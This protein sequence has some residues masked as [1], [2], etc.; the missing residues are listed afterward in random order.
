MKSFLT[1]RN[2]A[3]VL[4]A[5]LIAVIALVS[6]GTGRGDGAVTG[7]TSAASK[8]LKSAA[9]AVAR[10]F[11][12]IYGYMYEYENVV[13]ENEVLKQQIADYRQ[14]YREYTEVSEE[15]K[16]LRDLLGFAARHSDYTFEQAT[17][18][19]WGASN[20]AS[21]FTVSRGSSNSDIAVG[22]AVI[23]ETGVLV[24]KITK[25]GAVDSTA[26][27]VID[28][29]F[30]AGALIG[31]R[32]ADGVAVGDFRYM[33]DGLLKLDFLADDTTVL[34]GDT[35]VTSG[36]K[37]GIFPEGLV[38]GTVQ[39][40]MKNAAGIGMYGI[41]EPEAKPGEPSFVFIVTDFERN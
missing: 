25:V 12:T 24:G 13:A 34:A 28:T 4:A 19:M 36:S 35:V 20:W 17:I 26:V 6:T 1:K 21:T 3:I 14:D 39:G 29:T 7:W 33:R 38:I 22:D 40:V 11:E 23:T 31:E 5:V 32:G 10:T 8:P 15:N 41:I 30:S 16:R 9:A 27:S 37:G 18:I 2:I